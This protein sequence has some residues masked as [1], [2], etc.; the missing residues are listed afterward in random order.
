VRERPNILLITTD[1]QSWN[2]RSVAGN[3]HIATPAM[4]QLAQLGLTFGRAY[5]T[6][7]VCAPQR[8]TWMTGRYSSET[9]T[10]FNGGRVHPDLPDLGQLLDASGYRALHAGKWHV[11]GREVADSFEVLFEG[12]R[13]VAAGGADIHDGAI[14]K[15]VAHFLI[16]DGQDTGDDRPFFLQT[17][18]INPHDICEY[19]HRFETC[20]R[21]NLVE[22]GL[23]TEADL[24]P[25]PANFDAQPDET[26]V[27]LVSRRIDGCLIHDGIRRALERWN[28]LDWRSYIWHYYRYVEEVDRHIALVLD[29]LRA[30]PYA[31]DTLVLFTSDHGESAGSHRMF[32]KFTLYEESVRVPLIAMSLGTGVPRAGEVDDDHVASGIDIFPT[33]CD[34]A[35]IPVPSGT[36]GRSLRPLIDAPYNP[37]ADDAR[38]VAENWA[39]IESNYLG[40]GIVDHRIKYITEYVPN[41]QDTHLPPNAAR[42]ARGREQLFDLRDDP[43]ETR[44]LAGRADHAPV[45]EQMRARLLNIE[46]RLDQR[47]LTG[48]EPR[49]TAQTWS[50]RVH[51]YWSQQP[52]GPP[53]LANPVAPLHETA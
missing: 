7:P 20:H 40:R 23:V 49:V 21:P 32:Q 15:A 41:P 11:D 14:A 47:P 10:P 31:D 1:Q 39:Y 9:G 44:D 17:H 38:A 46:K 18:F 52:A 13:R 4:D 53:M 42:N 8:T 33:I 19:L 5:S 25:L 3:A 6:D 30:S 51:T 12:E 28:E 36:H 45:L 43:G 34:Y 22:Q 16:S 35:G 37:G 29:A 26:V 48:A 27:Q 2:A 24:P 50:E